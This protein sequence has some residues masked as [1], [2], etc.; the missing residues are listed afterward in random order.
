[1]VGFA[2][3]VIA[4]WVVSL[5]VSLPIAA[6]TWHKDG[7]WIQVLLSANIGASAVVTVLLLRMFAGWD[8]IYQRLSEARNVFPS[9][10]GTVQSIHESHR[11]IDVLNYTV[12]RGCPHVEQDTVE[13]EET[14]WADGAQWVK[15]DTTR[16][17]DKLLG[18]YEVLPV[19]D[20]LRSSLAIACLLLSATVVGYALYVPESPDVVYT[21]AYLREL[22]GN[23]WKAQKVCSRNDV[24]RRVE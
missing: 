3:K 2:S 23:E 12:T 1:M 4:V 21:P 7:Q 18:T 19:V 8:Y 14:G 22:A 11:D 9:H 16:N 10:L 13:F 6:E 15:P 20:R 5:C 24:K 17:R